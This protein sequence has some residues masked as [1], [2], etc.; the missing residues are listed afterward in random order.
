MEK[1]LTDGAVKYGPTKFSKILY[2]YNVVS[3]STFILVERL[4]EYLPPTNVSV[5]L[6]EIL[7]HNIKEDMVFKKFIHVLENISTLRYLYLKICV[8]F[9]WYK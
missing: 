7:A 2:K 4:S 9:G 3:S 5:I 6:V 1:D 8:I